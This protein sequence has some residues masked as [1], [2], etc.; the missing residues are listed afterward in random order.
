[1]ETTPPTSVLISSTSKPRQIPSVARWFELRRPCVLNPLMVRYFQDYCHK[2]PHTSQLNRLS[3]CFS[4]GREYKSSVLCR[5]ISIT[6][7][8]SLQT[9][10]Q[11]QHLNQ[12]CETTSLTVGSALTVAPLSITST[13]HPSQRRIPDLQRW[14]SCMQFPWHWY[15]PA[16]YHRHQLC[17]YLGTLQHG[18]I[19]DIILNV[20]RIDTHQ[21]S[22]MHLATIVG[23][24][25][26]Q[27]GRL[28]YYQPWIS[29]P[30]LR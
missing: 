18:M 28:Q 21:R 13:V 12:W 17:G 30:G 9:K 8:T 15:T 26:R 5:R 11:E 4:Y 10:N 24:Q 2:L 27:R 7:L 29:L 6:S 14:Q 22:V 23:Y 25:A 1:M 16:F 20:L 19:Y 3:R